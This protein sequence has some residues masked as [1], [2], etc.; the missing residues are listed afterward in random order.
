MK[1]KLLTLCLIITL[2]VGIIIP[3]AIPVYAASGT[4]NS[5]EEIPSYATYAH[6]IAIIS[7]LNYTYDL[8][9]AN[10]FPPGSYKYTYVPLTHTSEI[11]FQSFDMGGG[12][13]MW[14][15]WGED[16]TDQQKCHTVYYNPT[17]KVWYE[18]LASD[19]VY[20]DTRPEYSVS[21]I[22]SSNEYQDG[23]EPLTDGFDVIDGSIVYPPPPAPVINKLF[24][25]GAKISNDLLTGEN[26]VLTL[27][28]ANIHNLEFNVNGTN[29]GVLTN[30]NK[31]YNF[32]NEVLAGALL[33]DTINYISIVGNDEN[34]QPI[35][36]ASMIFA[37][38]TE[39]E[40]PPPVIPPPYDIDTTPEGISSMIGQI[41]SWLDNSLSWMGSISQF[42]STI[43]GFMPT[44]V[45]S[46]L[47]ALFGV[48]TFMTVIKLIR[49]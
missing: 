23:Y 1:K 18:N 32:T 30:E 21:F 43:F 48:V 4:A 45:K 12:N 37:I 29:F 44:E 40:I 38:V 9:G 46:G 14:K 10:V 49:G 13:T 17:T 2:A 7:Q 6:S 36:N 8:G 24:P 19:A 22:M 41:L 27:E 16:A 35:P 20:R 11:K 42:L 28:I 26:I 33:P 15:W 39:G 25:D 31:N 47:L 5:F 3:S 34:A